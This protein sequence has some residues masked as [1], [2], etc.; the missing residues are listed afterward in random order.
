MR[1][2]PPSASSLR[3]ASCSKGTEGS[4]TPIHGSG[5]YAG[6][7]ERTRARRA[8]HRL[9]HRGAPDV[10]SLR[11]GGGRVRSRTRPG[12]SRFLPLHPRAVS[13]HVPRTAVDDAPVR[14]H[15]HGRRDE[16]ALPVPARSGSD[17][18]QRRVRPAH[19]DG[20][21]LRSSARRGRGGQDGG[22]DRLGGG[23]EPAASTASRSIGSRRR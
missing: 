3:P 21:G 12:E 18:A 23:H 20:A 2:K 17:R 7:D 19:A 1:S 14:R 6:A 9:G 8:S 5:R 10:R 11:S 15:G 4:S 16:H 22:G 13:V